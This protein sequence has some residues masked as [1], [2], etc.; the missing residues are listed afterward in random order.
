MTKN[1]RGRPRLENGGEWA[2]LED[3]ERLEASGLTRREQAVL[4]ALRR[5]QVPPNLRKELEEEAAENARLRAIT[6]ART[7]LKAHR[8]KKP[9]YGLRLTLGGAPCT[10]HYVTGLPGVYWPDRV[11]PIGGVGEA[12]ME[13]AQRA[14]A[15]PGC[16]VEL[17][18]LDDV[19]IKQEPARAEM[20]EPDDL[21]LARALAPLLAK[22]D[23]KAREKACTRE[24]K[25]AVDAVRSARRRI[26]HHARRNRERKRKSAERWSQRLAA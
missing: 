11:T 16:E 4:F 26:H 20:G 25:A 22:L 18:E 17:V 23:K 3:L 2:D 19:T 14:A 6:N 5:D 13:E 21:Q 9:V 24:E 12:S 7:R 8:Q 15:D 10:P 1:P